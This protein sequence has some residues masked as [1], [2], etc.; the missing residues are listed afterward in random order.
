VTGK[1]IGAVDSD[2]VAAIIAMPP[3]RT[4]LHTLPRGETIAIDMRIATD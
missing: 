4:G 2:F 1:R 3:E